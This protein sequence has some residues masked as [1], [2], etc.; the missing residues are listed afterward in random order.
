MRESLVR[1]ALCSG[2][3]AYLLGLS[4]AAVELLVRLDQ[5]DQLP[6]RLQHGVL[7][8]PLLLLYTRL[9]RL[10]ERAQREGVES[11]IAMT[12]T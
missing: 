8:V 11:E 12:T 6:T 9:P 4:A 10:P 2:L 7:H 1:M 3:S 5:V